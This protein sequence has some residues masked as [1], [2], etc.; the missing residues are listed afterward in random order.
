MR[1]LD[2]SRTALDDRDRMAEPL[3][4]I[5]FVGY[6]LVQIDIFKSFSQQISILKAC[7]VNA[8]RS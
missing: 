5:T 2:V 6:R 7:G 1:D 8:R 4:Q 3:D